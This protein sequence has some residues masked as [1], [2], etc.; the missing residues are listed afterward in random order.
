MTEFNSDL[1]WYRAIW[2]QRFVD[3]HLKDFPGPG[4][5][6]EDDY[7]LGSC[8]LLSTDAIAAYEI[9]KTDILAD[10]ADYNLV[11]SDL[12]VGYRGTFGQYQLHLAHQ[13][14]TVDLQT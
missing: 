10:A 1:K 5:W 12:Q 13:E 2:K 6:G 7:Y 9:M 14:E 4:T 11:I 8:D 3:Q